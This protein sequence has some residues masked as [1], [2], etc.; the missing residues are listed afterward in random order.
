[1]LALDLF[2]CLPYFLGFHCILKDKVYICDTKGGV[3]L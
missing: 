3:Q 1:M 2:L